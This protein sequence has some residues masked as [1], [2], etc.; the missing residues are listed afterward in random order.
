MTKATSMLS[1]TRSFLHNA[2]LPITEDAP[3]DQ[4]NKKR[5]NYCWPKASSLEKRGA[6]REWKGGSWSSVGMHVRACCGCS[7]LQLK[8]KLTPVLL[9]E[10]ACYPRGIWRSWEPGPQNKQSIRHKKQCGKRQEAKQR[11]A[12]DEMQE[13]RSGAGCVGVK[14][15]SSSNRLGF[16]RCALG[17][18]SQISNGQ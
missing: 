16:Q 6:S 4:L 8:G 9:K 10:E 5:Q 7:T 17:S 15:E 3:R 18:E 11:V 13:K 14:G 1:A 2:C 12:R